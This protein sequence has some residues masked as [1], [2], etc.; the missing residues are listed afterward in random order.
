MQAVL[1]LDA[2]GFAIVDTALRTVSRTG[3]TLNAVVGD[4]EPLLFRLCMAHREV[5]TVD[6]EQLRCSGPGDGRACQRWR[7]SECR[8]SRVS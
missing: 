4:A 6:G 1:G 5:G 2:I 3:A 7:M 8:H